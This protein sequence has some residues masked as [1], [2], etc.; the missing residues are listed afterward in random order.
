MFEI[1]DDYFAA[2]GVLANHLSNVE[3]IKRVYKSREISDVTEGSQGTPAIHL[4]YY[5]DQLPDTSNGGSLMQ[6]KQIWLVI[7][8]IKTVQKGQGELLTNVIQSLAGKTIDGMGT[9]LRVNSPVRP[10]FTKGFSYYPLAFTCHMRMKTY[11]Q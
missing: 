6:I 1:T 5:G 9:W 3:G 2:E 7:L 11:R 10:S 8:A 4:I